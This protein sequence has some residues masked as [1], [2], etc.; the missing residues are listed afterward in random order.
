[1]KI[2][3]IFLPLFL[4]AIMNSCVEQE[5]VSSDESLISSQEIYFEVEHINR[6]WA[7]THQ[8]FIVDNSGGIRTY[9]NPVIWNKAK[10]TKGLLASTQIKENIS[11]TIATDLKVDATELKSFSG[12]ISELSTS[13]FTKRVEAGRDMGQTNFYAYQYDPKK[14]AYV[15]I[16][17]KETGD[18]Q[19]QNKDKAAIEISKWLEGINEKLK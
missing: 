6:G 17:L 5:V 13:E 11:K 3:R 16:L 7:D 12:K 2:N 14:E 8:G 10:D 19:T 1:M 18:W 9:K 4:L 15:P